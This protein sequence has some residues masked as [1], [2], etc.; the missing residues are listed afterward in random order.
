M[1]THKTMCLHEE[2]ELEEIYATEFRD[3]IF[4]RI[5][6]CFGIV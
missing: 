3:N 4:E 1:K 2:E 5:D 6:K